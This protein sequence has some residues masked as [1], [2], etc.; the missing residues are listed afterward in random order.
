M[1]NNRLQQLLVFLA[2]EPDEPFN[3]YAVAL[4]Y[5]NNDVQKAQVYLE[6]LLKEHPDYVATYYQ[7]AKLYAENEE[8]SKAKMVYEQ[9]LKVSQAQNDTKTFQELQKAYQQLLFEEDM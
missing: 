9:G 1:E 8:I 5:L 2:E 4:E 6:K 3:L 7:L